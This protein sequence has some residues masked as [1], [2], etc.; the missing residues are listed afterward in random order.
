MGEELCI[1]RT[2][3]G[4]VDAKRNKDAAA[5]PTGRQ[6]LGCGEVGK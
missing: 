4:A 5:L 1:Y 2:L 3:Q 6:A